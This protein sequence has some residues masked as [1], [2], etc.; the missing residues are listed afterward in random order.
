M[1]LS[2]LKRKGFNQGSL[3]TFIQA[4]LAGGL[5]DEFELPGHQRKAVLQRTQGLVV[6]LHVALGVV[7]QAMDVQRK[8]RNRL[9]GQGIRL[10]R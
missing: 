5:I 6:Q 10:T 4:E 3:F 7:Q 2:D 8:F 9:Q 1:T